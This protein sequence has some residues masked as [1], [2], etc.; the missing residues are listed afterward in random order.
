MNQESPQSY[1]RAAGVLLLLSVV[2]GAFGEAYV[3]SRLIAPADAT[4]TAQNV[5]QLGFLFRAGFAAYLVEAV[6]DV[7]LALVFYVLLRPVRQNIALLSAFFG[8]VATAA[9]AVAE[10][11]YLAPLLLTG[12]AGYLGTFSPSQLDT[13]ILLSLKLYTFGARAFMLLYGVACL[14][15]GYLLFRSHYVPRALGALLALAGFGFIVKNVLFVLAPAYA[16]DFLLLPMFLA[17]ASLTVWFLA[18][19]VDVSMW[20]A[21]AAAN[22]RPAS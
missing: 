13:L 19:G 4:L 20:Q 5:R 11:F 21:T 7:G 10:L 16:S 2:A 12:R 3:P 9:F 8:L 15:R 14:L 22:R 1:A 17:A 18:K 6:C